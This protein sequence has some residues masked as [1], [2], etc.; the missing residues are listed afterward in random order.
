[1]AF[2]CTG[3]IDLARPRRRQLALYLD[4]GIATLGAWAKHRGFVI[5]DVVPYGSEPG[6]PRYAE[7]YQDRF[8][9]RIEDLDEYFAGVPE[10]AGSTIEEAQESVGRF[11]DTLRNTNALWRF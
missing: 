1:L 4:E 11:L 8:Y 2:F 6:F 9:Y 7:K 10:I 3:R 5:R